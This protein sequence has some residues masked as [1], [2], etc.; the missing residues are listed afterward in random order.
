MIDIF[1][2]MEDRL[3]HNTIREEMTMELTLQSIEKLDDPFGILTGDRYEIF[4]HLEVP[5]D[6]E[7]Y[8]EGGLLLKVLYV[9]E[10]SL[11]RISHYHIYEQDTNKFIDIGLEDD[12][13]AIVK[14]M[15]EKH[16]QQ[17]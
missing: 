14:E 8:H 10:E 6:D 13:E 1:D 2:I 9:V 15:C 16:I 5:E 12:E 3:L 7:L 4:F 17:Q 11:S